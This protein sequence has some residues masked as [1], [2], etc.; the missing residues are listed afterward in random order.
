MAVQVDPAAT[1]VGVVPEERPE[2][3]LNR[4]VPAVMAAAVV[5]SGVGGM[6][7]A[8]MRTNSAGIELIEYNQINE[9]QAGT[10]GNRWQRGAGGRGGTGGHGDISGDSEGATGGS[11]GYGRE[12]GIQFISGYCLWDL[13]GNTHAGQCQHD[14]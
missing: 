7:M 12:C 5:I 1:A 13:Y 8:S 11:G 4:V 14:Q 9:I 2:V 3:F 10:G 6:P